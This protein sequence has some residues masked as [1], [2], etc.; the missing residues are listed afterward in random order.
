[1]SVKFSESQL[2]IRS[3]RA[4][5]LSF[6][7]ESKCSVMKWLHAPEGELPGFAEYFVC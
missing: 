7:D 6:T 5:G 4:S 3:V 1:M 2:M